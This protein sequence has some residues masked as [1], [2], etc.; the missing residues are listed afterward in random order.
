MSVVQPEEAP[1]VRSAAPSVLFGAGRRPEAAT[2]VR[3][4]S[5]DGPLALLLT[6]I[7]AR[8][9][10]VLTVPL[11]ALADA[12]LDALA[13]L[14]TDRLGN[15]SAFV[16]VASQLILIKS[17]AILPRRVAGGVRA[18][19]PRTSPTRRPSCAPGCCSTAPTATPGDG[20]RTRRSIG[21]GCSGASPA[22][23]PPPARAGAR[24]PDGPPLDPSRPRRGARPPV[25]H[26][27]AARRRPRSMA[28]TITLT[29]RAAIIRAA[30][31]G[32]GTVVL[33]DL[34]TGVRDRVVV[35]VTFLA[36]LELM[37][38]REIV[39]EQAE[40]WGPIVARATTAEE[41]AVG[42]RVRRAAACREPLDETP[43]VVRMTDEPSR[44]R[45][46]PRTTP[47]AAADA[48][49]GAAAGELTEAQLEALLFVAER[50][51]SRREIAA[52]AGVDRATVDA[53]LGDLEVALCRPRDPA[54]P[55][56]R[57]GRARDR[58]RRRRPD[59]P[60][61][62][63]GC[64]P[65]VAGVARDAG[66]RRLPPAGHEVGRR[67][68]PRRR[69]RLHDPDAAPPPAGRGARPLRG[70]RPAVPVRHELRVPGALRADQPRRAAAA[71]RRRRG[72]PDRRTTRSP[73]AR[74]RTARRPD[75]RHSA[76]RPSEPVG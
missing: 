34:L 63:R 39:V 32:A 54:R 35:A 2:Q 59:R 71:R 29:E 17:R 52:L 62:R 45:S 24:P 31:R 13:T 48:D 30:L 70:A 47:S 43:G 75:S 49:R 27:A 22:S 28:R 50:P 56:R 41:R 61:R 21:S 60:L 1:V 51:L 5:F 46:T 55:V 73:T 42:K 33:Q 3:L 26:R 72:A 18:R 15:V 20:S 58:A 6:L 7:E 14:E 10:D 11:G 19:C 57:P 53:R 67:A 64:R 44:R 36:M 66:D 65:P 76:P 37:K 74:R 8:Q 68:D 38:R 9:L 25:A 23:P 69:L 40:P 12:Y 4:E 16:A